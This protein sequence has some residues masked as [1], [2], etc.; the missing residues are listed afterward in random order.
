MALTSPQARR[1]ARMRLPSQGAERRDEQKCSNRDL[2]PPQLES[3]HSHGQ[4]DS[5]KEDDQQ[6]SHRGQGQTWNQL[7]PTASLGQ[8]R[9][10]SQT[11]QR[12]NFKAQGCEQREYGSDMEEQNE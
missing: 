10:L 5:R 3:C 9:D 2:W 12:Q 7:N 1:I 11:K 8:A 6:R 4:V